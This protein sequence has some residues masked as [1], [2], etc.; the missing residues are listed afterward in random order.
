MAL[1]S[2]EPRTMSHVVAK[3]RRYERQLDPGPREDLHDA[4]DGA[5]PMASRGEVGKDPHHLQQPRHDHKSPLEAYEHVVNGKPA[6]ERVM[7]R[8]QYTR[9]KDS[10][11]VNDPNAWCKEHN[12]PRYIIDLVCRVVRVSM[13]TVKIVKGLPALN[14][15]RSPT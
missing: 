6:I 11:I 5:G 3:G 12:Q 2:I 14:E 10:G 4:E 7:E 15:R 9:D 8:Y 13:E 1:W